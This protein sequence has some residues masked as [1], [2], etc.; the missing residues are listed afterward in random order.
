MHTHRGLFELRY[1][2]HSGIASNRG[3]NDVSSHT[4]K[5]QIRKIVQ[6]ED[7]KKTLSDSAIVKILKAAGLRIARRTVAKY[8]EELKIP[9]SSARKQGFR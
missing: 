7:P 2:F 3:G 1:F 8:R 5:E 6:G 4:V 9:S